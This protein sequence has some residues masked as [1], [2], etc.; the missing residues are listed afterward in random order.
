MEGPFKDPMVDGRPCPQVILREV[1][2][3]DL[4]IFFEQQLDAEANKMTAFTARDPADAAALEAH[5]ERILNDPL[6]QVRTIVHENETAGYVAGYVAGFERGGDS[7]VTYW[8]GWAFWG[9]GIATRAL[10]L[11]LANI[12]QRPLYARVAKDHAASL[13]VL[14]KCGIV[15]LREGQCFSYARGEEAGEFILIL[16]SFLLLPGT[17]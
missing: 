6:V 13:C 16:R 4:V 5:W 14:A 2:A 17:S 10:S 1:A 12:C 11:F 15:P 7:E 8:L 9:R 3:G